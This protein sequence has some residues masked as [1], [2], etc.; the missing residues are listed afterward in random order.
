MLQEHRLSGAVLDYFSVKVDLIIN[1]WLGRSCSGIQ[2]RC[3]K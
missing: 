3:F 2:L 1:L